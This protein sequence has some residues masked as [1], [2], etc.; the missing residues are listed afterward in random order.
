[1]SA[2]TSCPGALTYLDWMR[3]VAARLGNPYTDRVIPGSPIAMMRGCIEEAHSDAATPQV[4]LQL[5][6]R[7]RYELTA[8]LGAGRFRARRGEGDLI[9]GPPHQHI[10]LSGGSRAGIE[11]LIL[12]LDWTSASRLMDKADQ[13]RLRDLSR[14]RSGLVRDAALES[15]IHTVW[16]Q[17][18][19]AWTSPLHGEEL[20]QALF[21]H[22]LRLS[23]GRP[24]PLAGGLAPWQVKRVLEA[25]QARLAEDLRLGEL[26]ALVGLSPF[27]FTRAFRTA[28]GRTPHQMLVEVRVERAAQFL[29][30]TRRSVLD[31]GMEVGYGSGQAFARAFKRARGLTPEQY[32]ATAQA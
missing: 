8:D 25:M 31:I 28:A 9:I 7:G 20:T 14:L 22:L 32:R 11:M 24:R 30:T 4:S 29:A 23:E 1:M 10:G 21:A 13:E 26:A 3:S 16:S 17:P 5:C 27:H 18:A 12:A 15:L 19:A 2:T 6:V